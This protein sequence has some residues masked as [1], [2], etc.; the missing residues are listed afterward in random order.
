MLLLLTATPDDDALA[1]ASQVRVVFET[2]CIECHGAQLG[3]PK[4]KFGY[5][6]DLARV[7]ANPELVVRGD[8]EDSELFILIDEGE[9]PPE[10]SKT[11][12]MSP[13]QIDQV[14]QWILAGAQAPIGEPVALP[15]PSIEYEAP[16]A[17]RLLQWLGRFH[18]LTVH[19]PIAMLIGAALAEL[20]MVMTGSQRLTEAVRYCVILGAAGAVAA[21]AL[22]WS[23]AIYAGYSGETLWRHRWLGVSVA[24][25][26]VICALLVLR[27]PQ[28][29][30]LLRWALLIAALLVGA[31]GHYGGMLT[32]GADHY[33]W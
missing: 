10:K 2:K 18:P 5:V 27:M 1:L 31:A 7:A 23:H 14:K 15:P 19:F 20:W 33:K 8:P 22:G 28:R 24:V 3:K 9:M 26:A 13:P 29:R 4:G 30:V 16:F 6:L 25:W 17:D 12:P 21:A 11:G 32:Y